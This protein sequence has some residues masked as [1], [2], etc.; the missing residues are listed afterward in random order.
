M[1]DD[2]VGAVGIA[3]GVDADADAGVLQCSALFLPII[4]LRL[5]FSIHL[6][7]LICLIALRF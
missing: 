5:S 4:S 3:V 6:F 1:C 7:S 2:S